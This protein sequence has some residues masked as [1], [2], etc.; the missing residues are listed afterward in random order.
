MVSMAGPTTTSMPSAYGLA[1]MW[2]RANSAC[3]GE[4]SQV[5]IRPPGA[6]PA[7]MASAE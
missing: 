7:A 6:S 1:A 2:R 3:T 5:V 4:I